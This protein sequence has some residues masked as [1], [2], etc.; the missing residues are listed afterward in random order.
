MLFRIPSDLLCLGFLVW[1]VNLSSVFSASWRFVVASWLDEY[2]PSTLGS[3]MSTALYIIDTSSTV[4]LTL[5]TS[6]F[7]NYK[8]AKIALYTSITNFKN[9]SKH[10]GDMDSWAA[11]LGS[12]QGNSNPFILTLTLH[13]FETCCNNEEGQFLGCS[14]GQNSIDFCLKWGDSCNRTV[15]NMNSWRTIE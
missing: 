9:A 12:Q 6:Y 2:L 15:V 11:S 1:H 3:C 10:Q 5:E 8:M 13:S 7:S 4:D 14:H